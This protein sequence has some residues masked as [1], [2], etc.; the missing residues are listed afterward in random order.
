MKLRL[1]TSLVSGILLLSCIVGMIFTFKTNNSLFARLFLFAWVCGI[2]FCL[3]FFK[4][5][6]GGR[7]CKVNDKKNKKIVITITEAKD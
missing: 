5:D 3:A 4:M 6:Y 7:H 1:Y 2:T